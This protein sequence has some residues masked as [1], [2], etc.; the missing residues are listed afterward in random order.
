MGANQRSSY[1][2]KKRKDIVDDSSRIQALENWGFGGR[3]HISQVK[4]AR[5]MSFKRLREAW[6]E[7]FH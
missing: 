4:V 3:L 7:V 6:S 2:T 5:R 1:W